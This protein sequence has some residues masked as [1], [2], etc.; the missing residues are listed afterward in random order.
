MAIKDTSD[1]L[2]PVVVTADLPGATAG[3]VRSGKDYLA[4]GIATCGVGYLPLAPGTWGSLVGIGLYLLVRGAAMRLFFALGGIRNFN[5]LHVYYGVIVVELVVVSAVALAGIWAGSRTES[6]SRKKDPGKVVIDEVVGQF[7]ALI[8]VP[9]VLG[10]AWWT[11]IL[12]FVLFRFFDIVKPYP[13]R[14]FE[15]LKGGLGIMADDVVA[16]LYA[17][18]CVALAVTVSWFV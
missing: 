13:A 3:S 1:E 6:L 9:F 17:A 16:G 15:A 10:T 14:S 7:I 5:L 8:P 12:A 18:I 2:K 4:L 11:A